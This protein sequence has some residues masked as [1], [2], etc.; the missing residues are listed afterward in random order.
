MFTQQTL[1]ALDSLLA[2]ALLVRYL[3]GNSKDTEREQNLS[4]LLSVGTLDKL[5]QTTQAFY[6]EL[7]GNLIDGLKNAKTEFIDTPFNQS[8][9]EVIAGFLD[10]S[11]S[12]EEKATVTLSNMLREA[13]DWLLA[14]IVAEMP[15]MKYEVRSQH[16][17]FTVE[18]RSPEEAQLEAAAQY[19]CRSI[20]HV[21]QRRLPEFSLGVLIA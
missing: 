8:L 11:S 7:V 9:D 5:K 12:S 14:K 16:G 15:K 6:T 10:G 21:D 18:A 3:V 19:F 17:T 1:R 20:E 4:L 13:K 2:Q